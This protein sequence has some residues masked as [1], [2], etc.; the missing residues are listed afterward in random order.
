MLLDDVGGSLNANSLSGQGCLYDAA[1]H[2]TTFHCDSS[3]AFAKSSDGWKFTATA[4]AGISAGPSDI[5]VKPSNL[6]CPAGWSPP[7][8]PPEESAGKTVLG[9]YEHG[10]CCRAH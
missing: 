4:P 10:F 1:A 6:P 2:P 8:A 5:A 7:P 9:N 3:V